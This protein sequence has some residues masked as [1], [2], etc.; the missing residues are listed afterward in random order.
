MNASETEAEALAA[1]ACEPG[2]GFIDWRRLKTRL[3]KERF[4]CR[5]LTAAAGAMQRQR[6]AELLERLTRPERRRVLQLVRLSLSA[7]R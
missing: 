6:F 5:E 4:N 7:P 2:A 3:Y 1:L